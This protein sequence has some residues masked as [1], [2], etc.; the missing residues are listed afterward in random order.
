M[1]IYAIADLHLSLS[2]EKPMDIY[3]GEWVDH[4]NKTEANWRRV[5]GEG[6]TVLIAG[7][8]SWSLKQRDAEPDL[9][10][11]AALPGKKVLIRGNHD[12][13]WASV[14]RLNTLDPSMYFLQNTHY[15]AEGIAIC[16]SRGW[17]CPGDSNF[18][19]EDEKIYARELRRLEMSLASA[20]RAGLARIIVML[21]FPPTNDKK[22]DSGFVKLIREYGVSRV[23]YGHLH[24]A[25]VFGR[26]IRG[27]H[28]GVE[29]NLISLDYLR[30][31][32]LLL[33]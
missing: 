3:G 31:A 27:H 22:E 17:I 20:R 24:G 10:W 5:V 12:L 13:W 4:Q 14:L 33:I 25:D 6:D 1:S 26:S 21:H 16:G 8:T 19:A 32:P 29:Y 18:D 28:Y 7:D 2:G 9:R 11:I 30:C 23:V 15:E